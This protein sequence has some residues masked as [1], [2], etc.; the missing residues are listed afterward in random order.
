MQTASL[1][2]EGTFQ[3]SKILSKPLQNQFEKW[4][5]KKRILA[6]LR[7]PEKWAEIKP[8]LM[9]RCVPFSYTAW[10]R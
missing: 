6:C 10:Y 4:L 7:V 8:D 9:P 5:T 1:W 3:S 2:G